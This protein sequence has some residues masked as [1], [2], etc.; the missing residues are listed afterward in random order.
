MREH[1]YVVQVHDLPGGWGG[2]PHAL[3]KKN[4]RKH[5]KK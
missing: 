5:L 2:K 4:V 1:F 3:K